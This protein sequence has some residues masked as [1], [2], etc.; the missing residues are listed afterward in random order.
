MIGNQWSEIVGRKLIAQKRN[1]MKTKLLILS[2]LYGICHC[3]LGGD[4]IVGLEKLMG[5]SDTIAVVKILKIKS[6][7]EFKEGYEKS[8]R[9]NYKVKVLEI[10]GGEK[11]EGE[12][13]VPFAYRNGFRASEAIY[14]SGI[15]EALRAGMQTLFLLH[16]DAAHRNYSL[17]RAEGIGKKNEIAALLE[18]GF[19]LR[20]SKTSGDPIK[21]TIEKYHKNMG[22]A[23]NL[24]ILSA[25]L[26]RSKRLAKYLPRHGFYAVKINNPSSGIKGPPYFKMTIVQHQNELKVLTDIP[27]LLSEFLPQLGSFKLNQETAIDIARIYSELSQ[28][29]ILFKPYK[30]KEHIESNWNF[31]VKQVGNNWQVD[32]TL[33][34]EQFLQMAQRFTI[35]ISAFGEVKVK[36]GKIIE[37]VNGGYL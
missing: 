13:T 28:H 23:W 7:S 31:V 36:P 26:M 11:L 16:K 18:K 25:D 2:I 27:K 3:S 37:N 17:I 1:T 9:G 30:R 21:R 20:K 12:I 14:H 6:S 19:K 22:V 32:Y 4:V 29:K 8:F 15:E 24:K 33:E 35:D 10:I 5:M 34:T